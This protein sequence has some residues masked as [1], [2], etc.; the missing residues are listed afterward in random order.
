MSAPGGGGGGAATGG[1]PRAALPKATKVKNKAPADRQITAEQ[2]LREAK[3]I[4][5]EDEFRAPKTIL[6]DPDELA[7]YR[8][9]KRKTFEDLIRRVGRFN[10]GI[11]L[12]Y[13]AWEEAQK[14]FRRARSVWERALQVDYRNVSLW[15]KYAEMEMRHRCARGLFSPRPPGPLLPVRA[16]AA[17]AAHAPTRLFA[18]PRAGVAAI[19]ARPC[20]QP[21]PHLPHPPHCTPLPAL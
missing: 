8:L 21:R 7:E 10:G 9:A 17:A 2:I 14:D 6:S 15:L 19:A 3:E 5:L 18:P 4:Q 20:V 13:A 16:P 12:K 1:A 11:W